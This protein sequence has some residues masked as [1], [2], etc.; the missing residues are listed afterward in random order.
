MQVLTITAITVLKNLGR[1]DYTK[2]DC[3][4]FHEAVKQHVLPL[5][6]IIYEKKKEKLGFGYIAPLGYGSR[7]GRYA[8][9]Q[10]FKTSEELIKNP[11]NAFNK[12]RPFF[13]ECLE[14]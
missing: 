9:L 12:L 4:A 5:V 3:F 14:K 2:E 7:T 10:P 1:F 11:L 13:G 8:A 6:N